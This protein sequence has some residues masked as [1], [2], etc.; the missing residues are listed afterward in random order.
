MHRFLLLLLLHFTHPILHVYLCTA[1]WN[2]ELSAVLSVLL[3]AACINL[4]CGFSLFIAGHR[5][6]TKLA[7][8]L[9]CYGSFLF[10]T[11][12]LVNLLLLFSA[13]F[14]VSFW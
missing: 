2:L 13:L 4:L 7:F 10:V 1:V 14:I 3:P 9:I 5:Y 8:A 12:L 6:Y 11:A